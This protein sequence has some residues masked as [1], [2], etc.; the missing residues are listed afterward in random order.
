[1]RPTLID[2]ERKLEKV[3]QLLYAYRD[4]QAD[5]I[6]IDAETTGPPNGKVPRP[7]ML[8]PGEPGG[9][10]SFFQIGTPPNLSDL[11]P[12]FA[13]RQFVFDIRRLKKQLFKDYLQDFLQST[14]LIGQN[15]KYDLQMLSGDMGMFSQTDP[16][17]EWDCMIASQVLYAG[18]KIHH[19]LGKL[20]K[21]YFKPATFYEL[22]LQE[23]HEYDGWKEKMQQSDWT[24]DISQDQLKYMAQDVVMPFFIRAAQEVEIRD[25][26]SRY[27]HVV[28]PRNS[29]FRYILDLEFQL[30]FVY[31]L[32]ELRGIKFD[33]ERHRNEVIPYLE[34][35]RDMALKNIGLY[36]TLVEKKCNR[37]C[38]LKD[39]KE[40]SVRG[41]KRREWEEVVTEV[42]NPNSPGQLMD[43][44]N[45]YFQEI[46][47][48]SKIRIESTGEDVLKKLLYEHSAP[49]SDDPNKKI[50]PQ[51]AI[52]KLNWLFWYRKSSK[53][54]SSFG[55]TLIDLTTGCGYIHPSWFQIGTD[56]LA[57][58]SGRSSCKDPNMTNQP[59][60]GHLFATKWD[61]KGNPLDGVNVMEFFRKSYI[62]EHGWIFLDA[63]YSQEEMRIVAEIA[64]EKS[65][66]DFFIDGGKD[67][68]I[69][70][71]V[72]Q[73]LMD[74]P[75]LPLK[76]DEDSYMAFCRNYIGKTAGLSL[77]YGISPKSLREF[78]LIESGGRVN[79]SE[80]ESKRIYE[81][82]F[83]R[84]P[85]IR[86]KMD[87]VR[88]E[89]EEKPEIW[90]RSLYNCSID[91]RAFSVRH[92]LKGR[93]RRFTLKQNQMGRSKE[94]YEK[95]YRDFAY[96]DEGNVIRD[97]D[98]NA[99]RTSWNI[100][101]ERIG[102]ASREGF[103][104]SVQGSGADC[105]KIAALLIHKRMREAGFDNKEGI[106]A[107][108]HDE[109]L[110]HVK[111]ENKDIAANIIETS[112]LEAANEIL[113][114]VPMFADVDEG[115]NW[116][117]AKEPPK[118]AAPKV[119][120][121]N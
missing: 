7:I 87:E 120:I 105:L 86:R 119:L 25:F 102:S 60:R 72:A 65:L 66:I 27:D 15:L 45:S 33:V 99:V 41:L 101:R 93:P 70:A 53:L 3:S 36:R 11:D 24:G 1:M 108:I 85:A 55:Q 121:G 111:N 37:W 16:I 22:F 10:I 28:N 14:P 4:S 19:G 84:F 92:S 74:L 96:D 62:A 54:L 63:D 79:W 20:T 12:L 29:G 117:W 91:R 52:D 32:M 94:A 97:E 26:T 18:D 23:L 44:L 82:F 109:I 38:L 50:L 67:S 40:Q 112:M 115:P 69:H 35:Q 13:D 100:Y 77:I 5:P 49:D 89:T 58:D 107:L 39:R 59:S 81:N 17:V 8:A 116:A 51:E 88:M 95:H 21:R 9:W 106:V 114:K 90:G 71:F 76:K 68:D 64:G 83:D 31:A 73:A 2:D 110:C 42:I 6:C 118:K 48:N 113:K 43:A 30:I 75:R 103:N 80:E 78:M 61:E 104:H 57:V 47:G 98:G 34:F 46:F 56:E